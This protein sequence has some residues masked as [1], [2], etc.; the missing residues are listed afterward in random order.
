MKD[1]LLSLSTE[2]RNQAS[3]NLPHM[4]IE[5]S[6]AMMNR[7]DET[8]AGAVKAVLPVVNQVI[9]KCVETVQN[10][11]RIVFTGA[12]HSGFLGALDAMEANATFGTT[13]E[14]TSIVAGNPGD[15]MKTDGSAEDITENGWLDLQERNVTAKDF[16]I[17][18]SSSGRTPYV[19][20][21]LRWCQENKIP[22]ACL[23]NNA[24]AEMGQYVDFM[25]APEPG[26]EV[27]SGSTRLKP[28]PARR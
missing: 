20:G 4:S 10:G 15:I 23:T 13:D 24:A 12:A 25:M 14:F 18:L 1:K 8:C 11:G 6:T 5:E 2:L 3:M 16:V 27:I 17:G 19:I 26:P 9:E 28:V 21:A 22:C 7:E